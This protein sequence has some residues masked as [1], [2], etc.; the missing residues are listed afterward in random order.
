MTRVD[1]VSYTHLDGE[2]HNIK[3]LDESLYD[4]N[5]IE[6]IIEQSKNKKVL[7]ILNTVASSIEMYSKIC[8]L[9]TSF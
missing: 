2:R 4:K 7:I 8:L 3:I 5:N 9:Y 1:N 6:K